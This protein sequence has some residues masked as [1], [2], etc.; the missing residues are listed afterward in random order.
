[1]QEIE[2][3]DEYINHLSKIEIEEMFPED[4]F[5]PKQKIFSED[6]NNQTVKAANKLKEQTMIPT[7]INNFHGTNFPSEN[8]VDPNSTNNFNN[9]KLINIKL[10]DNQNLTQKDVNT[11]NNSIK[12]ISDKFIIHNNLNKIQKKP[13]FLAPQIFKMIKFS[14]EEFQVYDIFLKNDLLIACGGNFIK[15]YNFE[16]LRISKPNHEEEAAFT[17]SDKNE[18]FFA[19]SYSYIPQSEVTGYSSFNYRHVVAAGGKKSVIRLLDLKECQEYSQLIGHRNEIYDLKF[20]PCEEYSYLLLSASKDFSIR[21][22]NVINSLQV[23]IFGGP[24][25]H[26]ADVISIYWHISGDYFVSSG[27]DNFVK[28]WEIEDSIRDRINSSKFIKNR[29]EKREKKFKTKIKTQPIFSC[30]TIH[31]NYIDCVK[32]NGNFVLSKSVDG[33]IKEWLPIFNKGGDYYFII[34]SYSFPLG[35]K[36]WYLKFGIETLLKNLLAVG[37]TRGEVFLFNLRDN[38]NNLDCEISSDYDYF[39]TVNPS[40][41]ILT[42]DQSVVRSIYFDPLSNYFVAGTNYGEI[43]IAEYIFNN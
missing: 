41:K 43:Y 24:E 2:E 18:D 14:P 28:I 42:D 40:A 21:L 26:S 20:H 1:M 22:W 33:V 29:K 25:G 5:Y 8:I 12:E 36:I 15:V 16:K 10:K 17:F 11:K 31:E 32:F 35:E 4:L 37:N 13:E 6:A 39:F 34:N 38:M 7:N 3:I 30:N 23:C 9:N 27:V 19:L